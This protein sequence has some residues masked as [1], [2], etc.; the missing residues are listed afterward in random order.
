[1]IPQR[2]RRPAAMAWLVLVGL[3]LAAYLAGI[4]ARADD[5]RQ[6][7][8][9]PEAVCHEPSAWRPT[10]SDAAALQANGL[11]LDAYATLEIVKWIL[12]TSIWIAV[13]GLIFARKSGEWM[14]L[15]VAYF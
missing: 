13:G 5:Y 10:A 2:W 3:T 8:L 11:S 9:R 6:V 15:V 4:P 7:C 12:F 14:A 1:M